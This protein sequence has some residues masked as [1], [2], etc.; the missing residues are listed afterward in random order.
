MQT[1]PLD[2]IYLLDNASTDGTPEVLTGKGY[3]KEIINA[4]KE[5]IETEHVINM[6]SD[7]NKNRQI[8]VHY[9]RMN[10]NTGGAGGFYEGVKRGYEKGYDWLWLMDDDTI[11]LT[12]T[13]QNLI[14]NAV[15]KEIGFL[16]S[17]VNFINNKPNLINIPSVI[18]LYNNK[19]PFN[20]FID[21]NLL[22]VSSCSFVSVLINNVVIR[23]I[24]LPIRE[25]F[26]YCDDLEYTKRISNDFIGF[27]VFNSSVIH[28]TA[29]NAIANI[30]NVNEKELW[31]YFYEIRNRIY[32]YRIYSKA[33]LIKYFIKILPGN[34]VSIFKRKNMKLKVLT[35]FLF[36]IM[37]GLFFNPRIEKVK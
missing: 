21:K 34:F 22:L 15:E 10:E 17:H 37:N 33:N 20:Q 23:K 13:L 16:C 12:D 25:F 6:L 29:N 19:L 8:K 30:V 27:Y 32:F 3:I 7:G 5:P 14:I 26:I 18:S 4:K 2:A 35:I 28:K 31:K 36:G 11:C 1:Y 24:G 9:V